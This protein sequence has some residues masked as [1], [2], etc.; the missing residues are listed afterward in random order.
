M[1]FKVLAKRITNAILTTTKNAHRASNIFKRLY[2]I[3]LRRDKLFE[4][5]VSPSPGH[6]PYGMKTLQRRITKQIFQVTTP[7]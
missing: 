3:V 7:T 2:E 6:K 4:E 5:K 1:V